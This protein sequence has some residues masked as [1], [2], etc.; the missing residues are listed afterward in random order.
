MESDPPMNATTAADNGTTLWTYLAAALSLAGLAGTLYLSLGL[1]LRACPLCFYQRVFV[2]GV[3]AVLTVGLIAG[4]A[5]PG[6]LSLLALPLAVGG[7]AVAGWHNYLEQA[8][9]L[10]CPHG[11]F[12]VGTAP[13]QSLAIFVLIVAALLADLL[14]CRFVMGSIATLALGG[15]LAYG[16]IAT[17][18]PQRMNYSISVEEDKTCRPLPP[19]KV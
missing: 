6:F 2:M 7:L 13:Q 4:G 1:E 19:P 18:A 17:V 5:R 15:L 8:G 10:E 3:V 9:R 12:D 11:L 16:A 14:Q